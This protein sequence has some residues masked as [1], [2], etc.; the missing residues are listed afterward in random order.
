MLSTG[1]F[2][3]QGCS[4]FVEDLT[5]FGKLTFEEKWAMDVSSKF[6]PCI[7]YKQFFFAL[8]YSTLMKLVCFI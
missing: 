8:N 6:Q 5:C 1:S 7:L 3:P 2:H 4:C